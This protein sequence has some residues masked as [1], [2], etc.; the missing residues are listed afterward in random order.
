MAAESEVERDH[1]LQCRDDAATAGLGRV[2]EQIVGAPVPQITESIGDCV[3]HVPKERVQNRDGELIGV[4]P[5][6]Q[7]TDDIGEVT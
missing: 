1:L 6:P 2:V 7:I 3:Q 5:V 4:V